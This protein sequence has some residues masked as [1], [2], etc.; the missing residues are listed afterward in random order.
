MYRLEEEIKK[1]NLIEKLSEAHPID[2]NDDADDLLKERYLQKDSDGNVTETKEELIY[3]VA[4]AIT[5]DMSQIEKFYQMMASGIFLPNT[6]TLVNAQRS[7]GMLSACLVLPTGDSIEDWALTIKDHMIMTKAG[8]GTGMDMSPIRQRGATISS[9]KGEAAGAIAFL[10]LVNESAKVVKQGS[11]RP[12]ANMATMRITHPELMDFIKAKASFY[13]YQNDKLVKVWEKLEHFNIS[14]TAT[15]QEFD[16]LFNGK[17]IPIV[18]PHTNKVIGHRNGHEILDTIAHYVWDGG[19]PGLLN[20]SAGN[21][22][23]PIVDFINP[24]T[25][26]KFGLKFSTNPCGEQWLYVYSVCNLG[27]INLTKFV[28]DSVFDFNTFAIYV[29]WGIEFLD[30]VI[31]ANGFPLS[32]ITVMTQHLR[33]IGLG[34]MGWA[35]T[36]LMMGIPY[37]SEDAIALARNIMMVFKNSADYSSHKLADRNGV[38]PVFR[39]SAHHLRNYERTCIAPTGSIAT[40]VGC[41]TGIEPNFS[42]AYTRN[43]YLKNGTK[44]HVVNNILK[45]YIKKHRPSQYDKLINTIAQNGGILSNEIAQKIGM[46]KNFFRSAFD[47]SPEWH[48]RHQAI[49][50]EF[51]DN[52]VSKTINVPE[53]F[54]EDNIKEAYKLSWELGCKGITIYRNNSRSYQILNMTKNTDQLDAETETEAEK[55]KAKYEE[56]EDQKES[57]GKEKGFIEQLTSKRNEERDKEEERKEKEYK[58]GFSLSKIMTDMTQCCEYPNHVKQDGCTNCV[59]CGWSACS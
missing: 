27:S 49:F 29:E 37:D 58:E 11:I 19:D 7:L 12:S 22:D 17:N 53:E 44:F 6:P 45:E 23:N 56:P 21:K 35:D 36:L 42:F 3:R 14:I 20:L 26:E 51:V 32:E 54:T 24:L 18:E 15:D 2:W 38:A 9:T 30:A 57:W 59:T 8:I 28:N 13:K 10:G 33:N 48:I 16:A 25:G 31:D 39:N 5:D 52:A 40:I 41:S 46:K 47:V 55:S 50:Q 34:I 43:T 4:T 1:I